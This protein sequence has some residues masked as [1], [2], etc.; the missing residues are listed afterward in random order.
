MCF[1]AEASFTSAGVMVTMGGYCLAASIRRDPRHWPFAIIPFVF[2]I[3]QAAEG[4][5]WLGLASGSSDQ[6]VVATGVYLFFALAWWPFWFPVAAAVVARHP[7][8]RRLFAVWAIFSLGWFILA[9]LPAFAGGGIGLQAEVA[10]HSIRYPYADDVVF[11][12]DVRWIQT[13]LYVLCIGGPLLVLGPRVYFVPVALGLVCVGLSWF[14]YAH[15]YT[16]V[17]CFFASLV[18]AYCVYFFA[19]APPQDPRRPGA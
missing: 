1:C 15:A 13:G 7:Q 16:S 12:A 9:Y 2:G 11:G 5:T 3:Q 6:V 14:I 19:T 17:W 10:H 18:S 8:T 4:V